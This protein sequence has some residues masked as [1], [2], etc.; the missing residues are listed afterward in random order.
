MPG[1]VKVSDWPNLN[2][3]LQHLCKFEQMCD[4]FALAGFSQ[5]N[6]ISSVV[7]QKIVNP[8]VSAFYY[9]ITVFHS[10]LK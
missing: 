10:P 1:R 4:E 8:K 9:L 3:S 7:L 5:W 2:K 6:V